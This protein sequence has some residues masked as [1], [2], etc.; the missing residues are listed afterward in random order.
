MKAPPSSILLP[1]PAG[2]R[3]R[4]LLPSAR[5]AVGLGEAATASSCPH[6]TGPAFRASHPAAFVFLPALLALA[7][8]AQQ[9]AS[10]VK[11]DAPGFLLGLWHGFIFPIAFILSIFM[12]DVAVYAVPN[13]GLLYNLGFFIGIVFLGV[14]SNRSRKVYVNRTAPRRDAGTVIDHE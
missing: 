5:S 2:G 11:P 14:G 7:A 8:C 6:G 13:D 3:N 9:A 10:T 12:K 1:P 4:A